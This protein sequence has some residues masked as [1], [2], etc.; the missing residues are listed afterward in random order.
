[1][2]LEKVNM[3]FDIYFLYILIGCIYLK[4]SQNQNE[5]KTFAPFCFE[6]KINAFGNLHMLVGAIHKYQIY[7]LLGFH[8]DL[9]CE[10]SEKIL[11]R[12]GSFK[13]FIIITDPVSEFFRDQVNI[14]Q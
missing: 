11:F 7:V 8:L 6:P 9:K 4:L 10:L 3:F 5:F 12:P 1:M 2:I 14:L 13:I